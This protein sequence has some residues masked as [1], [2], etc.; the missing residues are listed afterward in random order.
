MTTMFS[1]VV[2]RGCCPVWT[3]YCS[4]GR[5]KASKPRQ[6]RTLRAEHPVEAGVDVGRDVA[7][8]VPDVQPR[9]ARVG[10]HVE[11]DELLPQRRRPRPARPTARPGSGAWKVP[12]LLPA[13]LPGGLDAAARAARC[14]GTASR[15]SSRRSCR[16]CHCSSVVLLASSAGACR[17]G[18]SLV[19]RT[20]RTQGIRKPLAGRGGRAEVRPGQRGWR[21]RSSLITLRGYRTGHA[22]PQPTRSGRTGPSGTSGAGPWEVTA[23]GRHPAGR[24]VCRA[25]GRL[26]TLSTP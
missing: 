4:A 21:R 11:D 20:L 6:C 3:A 23:G 17:V 14:S 1:S 5:P 19:L 15:R 2:L 10:E 8:R 7:Q 9:P 13:V 22:R 16:S 25:A 26:R 18:C 24:S 12:A